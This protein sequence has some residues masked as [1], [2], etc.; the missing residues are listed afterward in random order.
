MRISS[1]LVLNV[2]VRSGNLGNDGSAGAWI[3]SRPKGVIS[4]PGI[5]SKNGRITKHCEIY[6]TGKSTR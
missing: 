2:V 5:L 3:K 1:Y 6:K 4:L